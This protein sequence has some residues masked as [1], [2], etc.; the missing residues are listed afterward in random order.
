MSDLALME[1]SQ[2][3]AVNKSLQR[4]TSRR[5]WL[6]YNALTSRRE[7]VKVIAENFKEWGI[8]QQVNLLSDKLDNMM[9]SLHNNNLG[10]GS[11]DDV[12]QVGDDLHKY[13]DQILS[14][15]SKIKID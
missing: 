14:D 13:A 8:T 5:L 2:Q 6:R 10:Q 9:K 12:R 1:P 3:A 15:A 11:L 4:V 7:R